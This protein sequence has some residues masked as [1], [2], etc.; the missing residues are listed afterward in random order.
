MTKSQLLAL[1][2]AKLDEVVKIQGTIYDRKR[3]LT[4]FQVNN[5]SA[6]LEAGKKLADVAEH[7]G[8]DARTIRY[9]TDAKYKKAVL[10]NSSGKHTGKT[11]MPLEDRAE[12]KRQL[13]AKRRNV[14]IVE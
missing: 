8:V 6:M 14:I 7:F 12:Y 10:K 3:K 11:N 13:V 9:N 2:D 4:N 5:A 1:S